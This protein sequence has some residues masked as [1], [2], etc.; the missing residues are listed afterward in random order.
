MT[1]GLEVLG[2]ILN[3]LQILE[4]LRLCLKDY[5]NLDKVL[6]ESE[7]KARKIE[8]SA[9]K[10]EPLHLLGGEQSR[11]LSDTVQEFENICEQLLSIQGKV[12]N[13]STARKFLTSSGLVAKLKD[14]DAFLAAKD[15]V[16]KIM[17]LMCT[18]NL[19][20]RSNHEEVVSMLKELRGTSPNFK[21][22]ESRISELCQ[23]EIVD[24]SI[25]QITERRKGY[26]I[27][28]M[29][30]Y[31]HL[32]TGEN[33]YYCKHGVRDFSAAAQHFHAAANLGWSQAY[34]YLGMLYMKG[35]GVERC[36]ITCK[37]FLQMGADANYP[38]AMAQLSRC[39]DDGIGVDRSPLKS[40]LLA[41]QAAEGGD[42][43]GMSF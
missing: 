4:G 23:I 26:R 27:A 14:I 39:Y 1:S 13:H 20:I 29:T 16:L 25:R 41:K 30:G 11:I 17:V 6:E 19:E 2:G 8:A 24:D 40:A 33:L 28:Q 34:Y 36:D 31:V 10:F 5:R 9:R 3:I 21:V 15:D 7:T 32:S 37:S 43:Y 22:L 12:M 18:V 42:P 38:A 35:L